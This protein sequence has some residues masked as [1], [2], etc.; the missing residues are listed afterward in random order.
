MID[1]TH[2]SERKSERPIT[3]VTA[4]LLGAVFVFGCPFS[5]IAHPQMR[6]ELADS[7]LK[8]WIFVAA[9]E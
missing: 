9:S 5:L 1:Q 3:R 7:T 2:E 8:V 4:A 6:S